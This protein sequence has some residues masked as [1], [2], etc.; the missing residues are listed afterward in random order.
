MMMFELRSKQVV[1]I[2]REQAWDFF[3]NPLNLPKI[4]PPEMHFRIT[5]APPEK[6][7]AGLIIT[8][9]VTPV[10]GITRRWV[11][12]ITHVDPGSM[13]VD[14]QRLGPYKFWHHQHHFRDAEGGTEIEDVVHYEIG[15]LWADKPLNSLLVRPQLDHIFRFRQQRIREIFGS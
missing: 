3:S 10:L 8:Y 11:T 12:E 9:A 15:M 2:S 1:P 5:N 6:M 4:L 13:F 14:E 7:Y